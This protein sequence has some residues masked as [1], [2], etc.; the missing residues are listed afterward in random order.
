MDP[1]VAIPPIPK[2]PLTAYNLFCILERNYIVQQNQKISSNPN[3][4]NAHNADLDP[5]AA[6]RP[7][8][9]RDVVLPSNWFVVGMN[10][11]KRSDHQNHGVISFEN[12]SKTLGDRWKAADEEVK[13]FCK[14][15]ADEELQRYRSDQAAY[16]ERYGEEAFEAQKRTYRKRPK[17]SIDTS[18]GKRICKEDNLYNE[19]GSRCESE[20]EDSL[21]DYTNATQNQCE[22]GCLSSYEKGVLVPSHI[23]CLTST[24][25]SESF[26]RSEGVS[27]KKKWE[28]RGSGDSSDFSVGEWLVKGQ[29][30]GKAFDSDD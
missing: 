2:R 11:K 16:K 17:D 24:G 14:K 13:A 30:D 22:E 5:Y 26:V 12:L 21:H 19:D 1:S 7:Q 18:D 28:R 15:V 25:V 29:E 8:K 3:P 23:Q 10:R 9:Y 27:D 4:T 20:S 6:E